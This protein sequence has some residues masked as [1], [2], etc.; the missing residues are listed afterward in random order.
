MRTRNSNKAY[1][2]S[3]FV[4][5]ICA[6]VGDKVQ[7]LFDILTSIFAKLRFVPLY[8][9]RQ[10][11]VLLLVY[12]TAQPVNFVTP[13]KFV[14]CILCNIKEF[15]LWTFSIHV[16]LV[17]ESSYS[18]YLNMNIAYP[19]PFLRQVTNFTWVTKFTGWAVWL[20]IVSLYLAL[21]PMIYPEVSLLAKF[22]GM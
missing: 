17:A 21:S 5:W 18:I 14:T 1:S 2:T 16:Y 22:L 9:A 10:Y 15:F 12:C 19:W 20:L 11:I 3:L 6:S 4:K 8:G 13:V 7:L